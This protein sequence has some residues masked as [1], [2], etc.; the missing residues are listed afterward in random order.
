MIIIPYYSLDTKVSFDDNSGEEK[1]FQHDPI[2]GN[3][4]MYIDDRFEIRTVAN[5]FP[6]PRIDMAF[7]PA[8]EDSVPYIKSRLENEAEFLRVMLN[9][10]GSDSFDDIMRYRSSPHGY[11]MIVDGSTEI[12]GISL[13]ETVE[14]YMN[15]TLN[16]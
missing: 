3:R 4:F 11:S 9:S 12:E 10:Y 2:G 8:I 13:R 14:K 6:V 15:G 16:D 7:P 1:G 5:L